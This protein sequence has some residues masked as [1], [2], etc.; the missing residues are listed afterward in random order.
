M[1]IFIATLLVFLAAFFALSIGMIF[2]DIKLKGHCGSPSLDTG[3]CES[4]PDELAKGG[5]DRQ[6]GCSID[7]LGNK[8][9]PCDTCSCDEQLSFHSREGG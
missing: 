5:I 1:T 9:S 7:A 8:I 4:D 3:C 6:R 2:S